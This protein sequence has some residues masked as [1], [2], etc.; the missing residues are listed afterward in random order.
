MG[1][2]RCHSSTRLHDG[3]ADYSELFGH[4]TCRLLKLG[5]VEQTCAVK[6]GP[7]FFV[8]NRLTCVR[9]PDALFNFGKEQKPFHG[10]FIARIIRETLHS[11]HDLLLDCHA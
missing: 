1:G 10:I 9:L 2:G 5:R 11:L 3:G 4:V 8:S 7:D 6:E